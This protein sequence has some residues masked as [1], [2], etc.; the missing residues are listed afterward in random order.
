MD[1][2]RESLANTVDTNRSSFPIDAKLKSFA[3]DASGQAIAPSQRLVDEENKP[4]SDPLR[5]VRPITKSDR[6]HISDDKRQLSIVDKAQIPISQP[7]TFQQITNGP[8]EF[9][10]VKDDLRR[11]QLA[12]AA[13][14][15]Q[16]KES[17]VLKTQPVPV[18]Q[19]AGNWWEH[20][21]MKGENCSKCMFLLWFGRC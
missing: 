15:Q 16:V 12:D 11:V 2:I 3:T 13:T 17:I 1:R 18:E 4:V 14:H 7:I 10:Y 5:L 9:D 21:R 20:P 19:P 8:V 6:F